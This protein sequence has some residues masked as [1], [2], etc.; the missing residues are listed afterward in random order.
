MFKK[1]NIPFA[2]QNRFGYKI[3]SKRI[4]EIEILWTKTQASTKLIEKRLQKDTH[5]TDVRMK[6]YLIHWSDYT[7]LKGWAITLRT[8]NIFKTTVT[9]WS[10]C[11]RKEYYTKKWESM[12]GIGLISLRIGIIGDLLWLRHST[13][14]LLKTWSWI[15]NIN[16]FYSPP[17]CSLAGTIPFF[18]VDSVYKYMWGTSH[19]HLL[20]LLYL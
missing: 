5:G 14:G 20:F 4:L 1:F 2:V 12:Q 7:L 19:L 8:N 16:S 11:L 15:V 13:S 18:C 10:L 17:H 6:E 9:P 3:W